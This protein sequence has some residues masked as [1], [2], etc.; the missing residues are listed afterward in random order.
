MIMHYAMVWSQYFDRQLVLDFLITF[1]MVRAV[2][3]LSI[4][5]NKYNYLQDCC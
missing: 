1:Y 4:A 3:C 5:T 2:Y